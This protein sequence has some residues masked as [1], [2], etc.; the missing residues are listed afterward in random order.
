MEELLLLSSS[1]GPFLVTTHDHALYSL[2]T[3]C[4][5]K[6]APITHSLFLIGTV[7]Y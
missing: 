2:A 1:K 4:V 3:D 6:S 7:K 5:E